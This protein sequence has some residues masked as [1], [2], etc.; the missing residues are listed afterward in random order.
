MLPSLFQ[1]ASPFLQW[2]VK[3]SWQGACLVIL[4][5]TVQWLCRE[6]HSARWRFNLWWLL[7]A[8]LL[9]PVS[10]ESTLSLYNWVRPEAVPLEH[11]V[12]AGKAL[13]LPPQRKTV[14]MT[15][16]SVA[17]NSSGAAAAPHE[18]HHTRNGLES[19]AVVAAPADR[20]M[21]I[22]EVAF[23]IWLAGVIGLSLHVFVTFLAMR[24]EVRRGRRIVPLEPL[25]HRCKQAMGVNKEVLLIETNS[26]HS[27]ALFGVL[28]PAL[29]LPVGFQ[30][31]FSAEQMRHIFLHELAHVKRRDLILN[32]GLTFL[33]ILHWPNPL[34]WMGFARLRADRELA[35]D[36]LAI[37]ATSDQE[38]KS[39]GHTIIKMLELSHVPR[40]GLVGIMEEKHQLKRRILM[41][42]AYRPSPRWSIA[43]IALLAMLALFSL[44]DAQKPPRLPSRIKVTVLDAETLAPIEGATVV[45]GYATANSIISPL[46]PEMTNRAGEALV[47]QF[48][49]P[50]G[51]VMHPDYAPKGIETFGPA[52]ILLQRGVEIGGVI[53]DKAGRPIPGIRVYLDAGY[54]NFRTRGKDPMPEYPLYTSLYG[55]RVPV[56]DDEGRW[57]CPGFPLGVRVA[58]LLLVKPNGASFAFQTESIGIILNK[59]GAPIA[60]D[61]LYQQTA[62]AVVGDGVDVR[63]VVRDERGEPLPGVVITETDHRDSPPFAVTSGSDGRFL[64]PGRE[65][66][67]ILLSATHGSRPFGQRI[68]SIEPGI[69]EVDLRPTKPLRLRVVNE[70]GFPVMAQIFAESQLWSADTNFLGRAEWALAPA[71]TLRY[72]FTAQGAME[73]RL[74]RPSDE[75][76]TVTLLGDGDRYPA[77]IRV[78]DSA[79][80]PVKE[81][82]VQTIDE[83]KDSFKTVGKGKEGN[84]R[85][86]LAIANIRRRPFRLR[87]ASP[88]FLPAYT[89]PLYSEIG[90]ETSVVLDRE[91]TQCLVITPDGTPAEGATIIASC[92]GEMQLS[93]EMLAS[94]GL[95][96]DY[97]SNEGILTE[98][99][100][101]FTLQSSGANDQVVLI[102][103]RS[104]FAE[105]TRGALRTAPV[106]TLKPWSTLQGEIFLNGKSA[107]RRKLVIQRKNRWPWSISGQQSAATDEAGRFLVEKIPAG[108]YYVALQAPGNGVLKATHASLVPSGSDHFLNLTGREVTGSLPSIP[109]EWKTASNPYGT[110]T[111]LNLP[112]RPV[113]ADTLQSSYYDHLTW[114]WTFLSQ[115]VMTEEYSVEFDESGGFRI[116]DVPEGAYAL[117]ISAP[118]EAEARS[119]GVISRRVDVSA[120]SSTTSPASSVMVSGLKWVRK[121]R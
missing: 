52:P 56:S 21:T 51:A 5:L 40:P 111:R 49:I 103:H 100:G 27:P 33:Q 31:A 34:L 39:Y 32:W 43:A 106:V 94:G 24:L 109:K 41:I 97:Y 102:G 20:T 30:A 104:G 79:G 65:P 105:T 68:I 121:D 76:Q 25:F 71:E 75:V 17:A 91:H 53:R 113:S 116:A 15:N 69:D 48:A 45:P 38:A 55:G 86:D 77:V 72:Q 50:R 47:Y 2:L 112:P 37:A 119:R 92:D 11:L 6:K 84:G 9:L 63:G 18:A 120:M 57:R 93:V 62:V 101:R 3:A 81:Y 26:V 58:F 82:T 83:T 95:R 8:R 118:L 99:D 107:A 12:A 35:C 110:L 44:T 59:G 90:I 54:G 42:A 7:V 115:K 16:H 80:G 19:A 29:L 89:E 4:I 13:A 36:A 14:E 66:H 61:D 10:Y 74:L 114:E 87:I 28:W 67:Q 22:A 1:T 98:A 46:R 117:E 70:K 108:E 73:F 60:L 64:L 88:G 23:F 78:L 85:V 96:A